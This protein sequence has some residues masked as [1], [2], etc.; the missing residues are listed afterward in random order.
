MNTASPV[1]RFVECR[2]GERVATALHGT[3]PLIVCPA[4]WV[5]HL[6]LDWQEPFFRRFFALLGEVATV[7]RYD[8]PGVGVSGPSARAR[9]LEH[10]VT[11][12]EDVIASQNADHVS[13][14]G[15]SCGGPPAV[16]FA[17]HYLALPS[18]EHLVLVSQREPRVEVYSRESDGVFQ[19][20]VYELGSRVRLDRIGVAIAVDDL[21]AGAFELP[22]DDGSEGVA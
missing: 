1:I 21:Y 2:S 3:G 6:E 12:L 10:E 9:S 18:V 13:L 16:A 5:G 14:L 20:R 4:W 22:G 15:L 17:S 19:Y 8:R 7:L 11:V